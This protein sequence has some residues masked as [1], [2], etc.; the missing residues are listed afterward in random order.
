MWWGLRRRHFN[1]GWLCL[2][3]APVSGAALL[4]LWRGQITGPEQQGF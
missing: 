3:L 1:P 2:G 4:G